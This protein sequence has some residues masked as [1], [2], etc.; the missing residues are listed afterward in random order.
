MISGLYT[1]ISQFKLTWLVNYWQ[2]PPPIEEISSSRLTIF[3]SRTGRSYEIPVVNNAIQA[4][5]LQKISL[6]RCI[7]NLAPHNESGI[8]ILDRGF[9][10]TAVLESKITHV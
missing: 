7:S 1:L 8:L 6:P 4:I 10:N 3:D 2:T 9:K 5:H